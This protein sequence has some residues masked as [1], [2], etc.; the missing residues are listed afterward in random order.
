MAGHIAGIIVLGGMVAIGGSIAANGQQH[1]TP[2]REASAAVPIPTPTTPD[3]PYV[4]HYVGGFANS[5]GTPS[6]PAHDYTTPDLADPENQIPDDPAVYDPANPDNPSN[7][8]P[9]K[10]AKTAKTA[11]AKTTKTTK[12]KATKTPKVTATKAPTTPQQG[13]TP[14]TAPTTGAKMPTTMPTTATAPHFVSG[15]KVKIH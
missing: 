10:V 2:K 3:A 15:G 6:F 12:P 7:L 5:T 4:V 13:T 1:D 11:A 8:I 9:A 14:T